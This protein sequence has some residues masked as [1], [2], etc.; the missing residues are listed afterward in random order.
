[1]T[2]VNPAGPAPTKYTLECLVKEVRNWSGIPTQTAYVI[3][4]YRSIEHLLAVPESELLSH[5]GIGRRSMGVVRK[6]LA[7][8]GLSF[9]PEPLGVT[10]KDRAL[11]SHLASI[12]R[13]LAQ[14]LK[15]L[16]GARP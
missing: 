14:I 16:K 1:M 15:H 2:W 11:V 4:Q 9:A 7:H 8:H 6:L 10:G 12:D 5:K 13:Q 3:N